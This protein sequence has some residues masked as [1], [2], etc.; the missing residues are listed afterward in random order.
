[1][2][3][4]NQQPTAEVLQQ[5]NNVDPWGDTTPSTPQEPITPD[6]PAPE[7]VIPASEPAP[8]TEPVIPGTEPAPASPD[9][10]IPATE[11]VKEIVEKIVEKQPEFKDELSRTIYEAL[12]SGNQE[13]IDQ[14]HSY[15]NE[16]KKDYTSM[17]DYDVIR[18]QLKKDN[19]KWTDKDVQIEL[20]T[21]YGT[22]KE[23]IDL[24]GIDQENDPERYA[25]AEGYN[26]R[27][28]NQELLMSR[29]ARDARYA[30]EESRKTIELPKI[31]KPESQVQ[32]Q[33][34]EEEILEINQKWEADV[35]LA[36]PNLSDRKYRVGDE[37]VTYKATPEEKAELSTMMKNFDDV[38]YLTKRGWY[39]EQGNINI[40]K[41][42]EDVRTLEKTDK[43]IASIGTQLKT[44]AKKE[45]I[46]DIKQIDLEPRV[47][48]PEL[49]ESVADKIWS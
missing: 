39:D 17:S 33:Y 4:E 13:A 26:E 2:E 8:S 47:T 43:I 19:P 5:N 29:D 34:T 27:I 45:V 35:D 41:V 44:T 28:E 25:E 49:G 16:A 24:N 9:A 46:A 15:L 20:K 3:T 23:K 14:V 7:A 48:S 11:P 40:L 38:E 31:N 10:I 37:E 1:M 6:T 36:I 22:I 12:T 30:L 18:E 21:K 42:A 32:P